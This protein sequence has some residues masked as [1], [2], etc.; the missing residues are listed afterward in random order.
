[1]V[2]GAEEN[3]LLIRQGDS[4]MITI[5]YDFVTKN[6]LKKGDM[7]SRKVMDDK[8]VLKVIR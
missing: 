6:H 3:S 7:L 1:M 4:I 5:P 8:I 2:K